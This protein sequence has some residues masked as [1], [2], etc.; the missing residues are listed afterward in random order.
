MTSTS[1]TAIPPLPQAAQ[2]V[3]VTATLIPS[4][5]P[6]LSANPSSTTSG[7]AAVSQPTG[8]RLSYSQAAGKKAAAPATI[9]SST[10]IPPTQSPVA[11]SP[12]VGGNPGQNARPTTNASPVNGKTSITPAVP[13]VVPPPTIVNSGGPIVNGSSSTGGFHS[14]KS[15]LASG[16]PGQSWLQQNGLRMPPGQQ[17]SGP[18]PIQFGSINQNSATNTPSGGPMATPVLPNAVTPNLTPATMNNQ[19]NSPQVSAAQPAASGGPPQL[20]RSNMPTFGSMNDQASDQN[21]NVSTFS[22]FL[23]LSKYMCYT[24]FEQ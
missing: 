8:H 24:L 20:P 4:Q 10:P 6:T 19:I 11:S 7:I 3:N 18:S 22:Y 23:S 2:S 15:S 12:V 16:A 9:V 5:S 1:A 21:S 17:P 14:R 13:A